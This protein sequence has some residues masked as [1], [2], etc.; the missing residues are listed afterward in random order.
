MRERVH[1]MEVKMLENF[2]MKARNLSSKKL[3]DKMGIGF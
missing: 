1:R 3:V 2:R